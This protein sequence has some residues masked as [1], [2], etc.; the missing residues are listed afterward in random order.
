VFVVSFIVHIL[1]LILG[2]P[3]KFVCAGFCASGF[4]VQVLRFA[5]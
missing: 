1:F 3:C 2:P 4:E 5:L